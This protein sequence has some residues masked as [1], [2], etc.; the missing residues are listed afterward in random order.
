MAISCK[1]TGVRSSHL[2]S[3]E[4]AEVR[5]SWYTNRLPIVTDPLLNSQYSGQPTSSLPEKGVLRFLIPEYYRI[6]ALGLGKPV[7]APDDV[8][9]NQDLV[10][11]AQ[12]PQLASR[13]L[14][15][16]HGFNHTFEDAIT[17][18]SEIFAALSKPL[19]GAPP[20]RSKSI[21][22]SWPSEGKSVDD[23][24]IGEWFRTGA[25]FF[26]RAYQKDE[27]AASASVRELVNLIGMVCGNPQPLYQNVNLIAHS[28]GARLSVEALAYVS[29]Y[30]QGQFPYGT[31]A[32]VMKQRLPCRVKHLV[33]ASGDMGLFKF[34]ELLPDLL[35][36]ADRITL[37]VN[38]RLLQ[39]ALGAAADADVPLAMS[40]L[41]HFF[42]TF[43]LG[44]RIGQ[45][46]FFMRSLSQAVEIVEMN[47]IEG[48]PRSMGHGNIFSSPA[49]L[50]DLTYSLN[51]LMNPYRVPKSANVYQLR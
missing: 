43:E 50:N 34:R 46:S 36:V 40:R 7:R 17:Y 24:N 4:S 15:F 11:G 27:W 2:V 10:A 9:F 25:P 41:F 5:V 38:G 48:D 3:Q 37:Y 31:P 19:P 6:G 28:L 33:L 30:Y 47:L 32:D 8:S 20:F 12:D 44:P 21:V 51:G 1:S 26:A 14:I 42:T 35:L 16:V 23:P 13:A 22:F 39:G 45:K 29:R 49:V 18:G